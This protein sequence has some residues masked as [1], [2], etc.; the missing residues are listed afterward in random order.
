M[1]D[2]RII[3][4]EKVLAMGKAAA[5]AAM[6]V[7]QWA[8]QADG[9]IASVRH[10]VKDAPEVRSR[11]R[12][13]TGP[14]TQQGGV[15]AGKAI[16]YVDDQRAIDE[17]RT[18]KFWMPQLSNVT[19]PN[20][21]KVIT[22]D[23]FGSV[24]IGVSGYLLEKFNLGASVA[25]PKGPN[26]QMPFVPRMD[27]IPTPGRPGL[28]LIYR[29][30]WA[31]MIDRSGWSTQGNANWSPIRY[32]RL[33][34]GLMVPAGSAPDPRLAS[35]PPGS[36]PL[37]RGWS[38]HPGRGIVPNPNVPV[39][40]TNGWLKTGG[41]VM[42]WGGAG[43]TVYGAGYN[44]WQQDKAYH[45]EMSRNERLGRA[46]G[47]AAV[48]GGPAAAGALAAGWAGAKAGAMGG[49]YVGAFFGPWGATIGGVVGGLGGGIGA[50]FVG[51]KAGAATGR[52]LKKLF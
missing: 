2:G 38:N 49:A 36:M 23:E 20:L 47:N 13:A 26:A 8:R 40:R 7:D 39:F 35:R 12:K 6:E 30:D 3:D 28:S 19:D 44:Q 42:K 24:P 4:P 1:G 51:S 50:G 27:H 45:P 32:Q 14:L 11:S 31:P 15:A 17:L 25:G 5:K 18:W 29:S 48:E 37:P 41:N 9:T 22:S 33:P 52:W 10:L 46:A 21:I 34:S 16:K 43:L